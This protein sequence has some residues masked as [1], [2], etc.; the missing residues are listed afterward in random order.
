MASIRPAVV[1]VVVAIVVVVI[2]VVGIVEISCTMLGSALYAI[3]E[4]RASLPSSSLAILT[5]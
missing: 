3:H 5:I 4:R 2:V 1:V